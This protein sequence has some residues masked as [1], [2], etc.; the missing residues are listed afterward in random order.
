MKIEIHLCILYNIGEK[1]STNLGGMDD[2]IRSNDKRDDDKR[3][4]VFRSGEYGRDSENNQGEDFK[5]VGRREEIH[6]G[7]SKSNIFSDEV[8]IPNRGERGEKL[9]DADEPLQGEEASGTLNGSSEKSNQLYEGR[10]TEDD[11]SLE[12][13][14]RES[15]RI[16]SDDFSGKRD[17]NQGS[18]GSLEKSKGYEREGAVNASFFYSKDNIENLS[19]N[20]SMEVEEFVKEKNI[21]RVE[22]INFVATNKLEE[23]LQGTNIKLDDFSHEQLEEIIGAIKSYDFYGNEI[24]E[25]ADPKLPVWKMEQ[26]KWLIDDWNKDKVGVT[27]EKIKYLKDL[28]IEIAK[29]NVLKNYLVNDDI[30]VTQINE[31]EK[32]IDD[33]SMSD[34]VDKLK[35]YTE[36][37]LSE[38]VAIKV[39]NEFILASKKDS[40]AIDLEDTERKVLVDDK[41]Y[42][43]YKGTSFK[44]SQKVDELID[45]GKYEAYKIDDYPVELD[46]ETKRGVQ[47]N[48]FEILNQDEVI[49]RP[50]FIIGDKVIYKGK[51]YTIA[52]FDEIKSIGLKTVTIK[53]NTEYFGGMISGSDVIPYRQDKELERIFK[54]KEKEKV[55]NFAITNEILPDK[56]IPS[57]RLNNNIDAISMLNRIESGER[58]LDINTQSSLSKYVGWGG[59]SEVFDESKE[60]QWKVAREF[61]KENLSQDE[62]EKAKEST[63]T[64]FY[65]PKTVI[66]VMYKTLNDMVFK[67]G[68]IL[69]PSMGIGN[70]IGNIKDEMSK[71]KIYGVELDNLSGRISKFLY[72]LS[73]VQIKGFEETIFSNN[74]FVFAV[75]NVSFG[76]FKVND[77][78]YN[79]NNFLIHDYFFAKSIDKVRNGG[80]IAF[81][82]SSGTLDK[83][84]E[85]IRKYTGARVEF[86]GEIWL[87]SDTFEGVAGTEVTSDIIFLKKRD[88]I[89]EREKDWLHLATVKMD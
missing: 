53:S 69:E 58:E 9:S 12:D 83:K 55:E 59:L 8:G 64:A 32:T 63:L 71:L 22:A 17:D 45:S 41:E 23:A 54:L 79:K 50:K 47:G 31:F 10:K 82:T 62:Y 84:D 88:S 21:E 80:I 61:L 2:V 81:I 26:I 6:G 5:R 24:V 52:A 66:D 38:K 18:S 78:E 40:F 13:R 30:S 70:F 89:L 7:I 87:P 29:F 19:P 3:D 36:I 43:I 14:G 39:G 46:T 1:I 51:E 73:D 77:R 65:T 86:L 33:L 11:E 72:P 37:N 34:F 68:N 49:N 74:F 60:G 25:I 42:S 56:L 67:S 44:E 28:N 85:S 27:S 76:E 16:Q 15:S 35:E 4:G 57:E 20:F 75:G 48:I